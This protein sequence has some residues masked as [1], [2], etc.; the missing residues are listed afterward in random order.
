MSENGKEKGAGAAK[1]PG[2][3]PLAGALKRR[4]Y[5]S[6]SVVDA[7]GEFAISLDARLLR[8]PNKQPLRVPTRKLAE[9]LA[10]E[11]ARQQ[12]NIEPETMPLTR[13]VN[14]AIDGVASHLQ[15]VC[16]D[17]QAFAGSDLVCYRAEAPAEL[18]AA[19]DAAWNPVIAWARERLGASFVIAHGVMPVAQPEAALARVGERLA[20]ETSWTLTALHQMTTLSGSALLA[21]ACRMGWLEV[22]DA[23]Q[24][25]HVDEDWQIRMWGEDREAR[26]RRERRWQ[27]MQAAALLLHLV[28]C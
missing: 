25:A 14:T 21:L 11:W 22:A 17:I 9:A 8:T 28:E 18:V 7:E 3:E 1:V 16:D 27:D 10:Q 5:H 6:V 15:A 13:L 2:R 24:R 12:A 26:E 4:F 20:G 23:W 19:Q